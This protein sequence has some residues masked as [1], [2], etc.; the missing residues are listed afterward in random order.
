MTASVYTP[1]TNS[2][3]FDHVGM[4]PQISP[5]PTAIEQPS[6]FSPQRGDNLFS[7]SPPSNLFSSSMFEPSIFSLL[8]KAQQAL[9]GQLAPSSVS[10]VPS[11]TSILSSLAA[12]VSHSNQTSASN[13]SNQFNSKPAIPSNL[14]PLPAHLRSINT[15]TQPRLSQPVKSS[16]QPLTVEQQTES[17]MK[18]LKYPSTN[19]LS[20]STPPV[21]NYTLPTNLAQSKSKRRNNSRGL[22]MSLDSFDLTDTEKL[23]NSLIM[24]ATNA[25]TTTSNMAISNSVSIADKTAEVLQPN[26]MIGAPKRLLRSANLENH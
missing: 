26:Q 6:I 19:I 13:Q 5:K 22:E 2:V 15:S 8:Q 9:Q 18:L 16:F 25:K 4:L 12:L 3:N 7:P 21:V 1:S 14:A 10:L 11:T 23:N 24:S 20:K 17:L